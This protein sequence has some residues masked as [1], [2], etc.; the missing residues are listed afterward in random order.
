[1]TPRDKARKLQEIADRFFNDIARED[2]TVEEVAGLLAKMFCSFAKG[3][4]FIRHETSL[5]KIAAVSDCCCDALE[6]IE[7][8]RGKFAEEQKKPLAVMPRE[9]KPP[10]KEKFGVKKPITANTVTQPQN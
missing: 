3:F 9:V 5:A 1:M 8:I 10:K 4:T 7:V 6:E 2:F